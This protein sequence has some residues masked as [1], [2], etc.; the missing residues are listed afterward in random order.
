MG[1]GVRQGDN[2]APT[3][4]IMVMQM[5]SQVIQDEFDRHGIHSPTFHHSFNADGSVKLHTKKSDFLATDRLPQLLYVD[6]GALIFTSAPGTNLGCH[7][8]A[9]SMDRFGSTVHIGQNHT[10][11]KSEAMFFPSRSTVRKWKKN[12]RMEWL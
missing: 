2:L 8:T 10:K 6:D 3:L 11:A 12:L 4:F 5:V 7:I 9:D 1:C